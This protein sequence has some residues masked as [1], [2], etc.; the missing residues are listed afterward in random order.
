[1]TTVRKSN[2]V[3]LAEMQAV[4]LINTNFCRLD[5]NVSVGIHHNLFVAMEGDLQIGVPRKPTKYEQMMLDKIETLRAKLAI[6]KQ[7]LAST[8]VIHRQPG[9]PFFVLQGRDPQAPGL[10]YRWAVD[11]SKLEGADHSKVMEAKTIAHA[12]RDFKE[13]NPTIG[14][15]M[16]SFLNVFPERK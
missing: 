9:E 13:A 16:E 1:M 8:E 3:I 6:A 12:M 4:S 5:A 7:H 14:L 15:P 2:E 10:V 11:R